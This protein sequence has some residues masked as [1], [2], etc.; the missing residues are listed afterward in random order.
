[1]I[2]LDYADMFDELLAQLAAFEVLIVL[3]I[4]MWSAESLIVM[5]QR[6]LK[7]SGSA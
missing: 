5:I 1:M 3:V 6:I 7:D 4:A 2:I